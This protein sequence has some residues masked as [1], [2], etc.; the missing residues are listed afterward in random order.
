M[1]RHFCAKA[2]RSTFRQ[3]PVV[4]VGAK[5][6]FCRTERQRVLYRSLSTSIHN[7]SL[8]SLEGKIER[9]TVIQ[10]EHTSRCGDVETLIQ[11]LSG[12]EISLNA[13]QLAIPKCVAIMEQT[14]LWDSMNALIE[15]S[16]ASE[17]LDAIGWSAIVD[18]TSRS[19][20]PKNAASLVEKMAR[21]NFS[22][23]PDLLK[24]IA[25]TISDVQEL[26]V[27]LAMVDTLLECRFPPP[28]EVYHYILLTCRFCR[29]GEAAV[30]VLEVM[31]SMVGQDMTQ[32]AYDVALDA[33][34]L[35]DQPENALLVLDKLRKRNLRRHALQADTFMKAG[36]LDG[37]F[38]TILDAHSIQINP[39]ENTYRT[40]AA[41]LVAAGRLD[42]ADS[43][44][45]GLVQ[46]QKGGLK[47]WSRAMRLWGQCGEQKRMERVLIDM[48]RAGLDP[49]I[50]N[51][52][53]LLGLEQ[54]HLREGETVRSHLDSL[55]A[56]GKSHR[57]HSSPLGD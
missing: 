2:I 50:M 52:K 31:E 33:C 5:I 37:A 41:A 15:F 51:F 13:F 44:I 19:P 57:T 30:K 28:K 56:E 42:D 54:T 40:I 49:W 43:V 20:F 11:L 3:N 21:N 18:A 6:K 26:P 35:S 27:L 55:N 24:H 46:Q 38:S 47:S 8:D 29:Q 9:A 17:K 32:F 4:S 39:G 48:T 14:G 34:Q 7:S 16:V 53:V 10:L 25:K 23:S 12:P 45:S 1:F 36:N 22:P